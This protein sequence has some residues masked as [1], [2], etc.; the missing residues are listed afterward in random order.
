[1]IDLDNQ[2]WQW[3]DTDEIC[4]IPEIIEQEWQHEYFLE[5]APRGGFWADVL[6]VGAGVFGATAITWLLLEAISRING[7]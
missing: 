3:L 7:Y 6:F 1:M 2:D 4:S 5:T